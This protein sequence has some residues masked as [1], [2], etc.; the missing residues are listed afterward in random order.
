LAILWLG[1]VG[2]LLAIIFGSKGLN[3]IRK[4]LGR[5]YGAGMATAGM[6]IGAIG[7][8]VAMVLWPLVAWVKTMEF[9]ENPPLSHYRTLTIDNDLSK[10]VNLAFCGGFVPCAVSSLPVIETFQDIQT[11]QPGQTTSLSAPMVPRNW[12]PLRTRVTTPSG[13]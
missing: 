9:S 7:V 2:S 6:V 3:Q 13:V 5:Q 4:S 8:V 12:Q 1:G 11:L 10:P